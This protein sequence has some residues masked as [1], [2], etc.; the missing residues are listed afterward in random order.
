[1][2][3]LAMLEDSHILALSTR[4]TNLQELMNLGINGLN[5]PRHIIQSAVYN[6]KDSIHDATIDVLSSW[7]KQQAN[8]SEAYVNILASLEKCKMTQLATQL[9]EWAE[10]TADTCQTSKESKLKD[11][12]RN[13]VKFVLT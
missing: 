3:I 13:C 10:G 5:L 6:S 1:M 4:I 2:H 7:V 12:I 11:T 8:M 9:R